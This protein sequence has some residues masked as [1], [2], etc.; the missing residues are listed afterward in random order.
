MS[1]R[2]PLVPPDELPE[3]TVDAPKR[4]DRKQTMKKKSQFGSLAAGLGTGLIVGAATGY[5]ATRQHL[6]PQWAASTAS[7]ISHQS[8]VQL[9]IAITIAEQLL[10][11]EATPEKEARRL[12]ARY[13][14]GFLDHAAAYPA[15][16]GL[17][18]PEDF[19]R[20]RQLINEIAAKDGTASP[21]PVG[22]SGLE[23]SEPE[24]ADKKRRRVILPGR[25]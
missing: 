8:Q 12:T 3:H 6:E 20:A 10:K 11:D 5:L 25:Q 16:W 21:T 23:G 7:S 9:G 4:A 15:A 14:Q 22:S 2:P 17:A 1:F 24:D 13:L 18:R 19:A